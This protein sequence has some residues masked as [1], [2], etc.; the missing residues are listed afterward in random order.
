MK[1][2]QLK[3]KEFEKLFEH[4]AHSFEGWFFSSMWASLSTHVTDRIWVI[5]EVKLYAIHRHLSAILWYTLHCMLKLIDQEVMTFSHTLFMEPLST[6]F[7]IFS[8]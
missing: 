3:E 5:M 2:C 8:T 6:P 1:K 7:S 4:E